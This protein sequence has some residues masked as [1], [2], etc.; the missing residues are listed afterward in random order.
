MTNV[1]LKKWFLYK[2]NSC[3]NVKHDDYPVGCYFMVYNKNFC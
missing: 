2:F 3:Y 1:E